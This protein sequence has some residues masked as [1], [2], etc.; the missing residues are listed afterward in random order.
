MLGAAVLTFRSL[1]REEAMMSDCNSR[2]YVYR[3]LSKLDVVAELN[4]KR[5]GFRA[6]VPRVMTTKRHARRFETRR[7]P[8]FPRYAFIELDIERQRWRSVNGTI[9]VEAL[10]LIHGIP[11][12][13][14]PGVVEGLIEHA[15]TNGIIDLTQKMK[16]GDH[17]RIKS[18]AF[19][20]AIGRLNRLDDKARVELLLDILS[21][22]MRV[23]V[24]KDQIEKI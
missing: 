3:S 6:F 13:V 21:S 22:N 7:E 11:A 19:A 15:D 12:P 9:G 20:G 14:P 18:G 4:L 8:L 17:V 23:V 24:N 16:S 5:Q 2:W 1:Y 10:I